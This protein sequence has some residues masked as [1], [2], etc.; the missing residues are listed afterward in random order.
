MR[1]DELINIFG[2][3]CEDYKIAS[4]EDADLCMTV[5]NN[6]FD[7]LIDERVLIKH[8]GKVTSGSKLIDWEMLYS[9]NG[10]QY[11]KKWFYQHYFPYLYCLNYVCKLSCLKRFESLNV[12]T[13]CAQF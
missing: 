11:R 2:K 3:W 9:R 4:G 7:I 12:R 1:R 6:N 13:V 10:K 8:K 5:W